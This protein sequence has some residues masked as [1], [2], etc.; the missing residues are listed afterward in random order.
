M[1]TTLFKKSKQLFIL[2][3][4]LYLCAE[5]VPDSVSQ[6]VVCSANG[7]EPSVEEIEVAMVIK[8]T[9]FIEWPSDSFD[10]DSD[11]FTIALLGENS[12]QRLFEPFTNRLFHGK[13][14][15]IITYKDIENI[16]KVQILIVSLSAKENVKPLLD[17]LRG[18]PVLT[19][20]DFPGFAAK[21][22]IIN[23]FRKANNRI[24]FEINM[25]S[26]ELSG[27]KI[28]SHL[29]KLG[30]IVETGMRSEDI[31]QKIRRLRAVR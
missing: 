28:S 5:I 4:I 17:N 9:D 29:L 1:L 8:F 18:K 24:G 6:I 13:K 19:I 16:G 10:K 11:Y 23:F 7:Q 15:R 20:G 31:N 27:I 25:E 2:L 12:Y 22:G 3:T 21:G 14:L 26:K 30:K